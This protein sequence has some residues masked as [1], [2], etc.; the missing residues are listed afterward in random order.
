MSVGPG[1]NAA[2]GVFDGYRWVSWTPAS[3]RADGSA[4][5]LPAIEGQ[6]ASYRW[7]SMTVPASPWRRGRDLLQLH[8]GPGPGGGP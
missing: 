6:P 3:N 2:F 1:P 4:L 5:A 8:G 7:W